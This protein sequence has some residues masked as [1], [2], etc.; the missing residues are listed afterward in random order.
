[1]LGLA[2]SVASVLG[3]VLCAE[4]RGMLDHPGGLRE[5]AAI[6]QVA[7]NRAR[8]DHRDLVAELRRP[9][10][11]ARPTCPDGEA[12]RF[13]LVARRF[14]ASQV[15]AP[16]W[17]RRAVAFATLRASRRV[18][19]AWRRLGYRPINGTRTVHVFWRSE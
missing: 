14:L 3:G 1:M 5:V 13:E 2:L 7:M 11:W 8:R 6:A 15:M 4:A 19:G 18:S 10:Q 12:M 17:A 9:G 16:R